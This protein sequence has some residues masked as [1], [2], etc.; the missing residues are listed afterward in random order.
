V[1]GLGAK[2]LLDLFDA[3][4]LRVSGGSACGASKAAPSYV[5]Q[6]MGLPAWRAASAV[7]LSFGAA[8]TD[9]TLEEACRRVRACG[10]S[11]R[12]TCQTPS[13]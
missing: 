11:L 13:P 2:L 7:R 8:D 3:A 6:A 4:G 10:E 5:L 9:A 12:A 1:P